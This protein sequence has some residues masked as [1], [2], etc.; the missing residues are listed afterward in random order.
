MIQVSSHRRGEKNGA[1]G[2][3]EPDTMEE[4]WASWVLGICVCCILEL[5]YIV[6]YIHVMVTEGTAWA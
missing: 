2:R 3:G 1:C 5:P 4:M 6:R